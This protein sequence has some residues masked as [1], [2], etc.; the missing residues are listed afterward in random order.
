M[1]EAAVGE[2]AISS[3]EEGM[4]LFQIQQEI[5]PGIWGDV[6]GAST[7]LRIMGNSTYNAAIDMSTRTVQE[8]EVERFR[9]VAR[10]GH[11]DVDMMTLESLQI[12]PYQARDGAALAEQIEESQV[13]FLLYLAALFGLIFGTIMLV[14]YRQ[15]MNSEGEDDSDGVQGEEQTALV[16]AESSG[17]SRSAPPPPPGIST[18]PPPPPPGLSQP[19]SPPPP[20]VANPAPVAAAPSQPAPLQWTDEQLAAQG[21]SPQQIA[22]WRVQQA[23]AAYSQGSTSTEVTG[24][25][26][27][28]RFSERVVDHVMRQHGITDRNAFLAAAEFFDSDG[29][30]YLTTAELS[31]AAE[32]LGEIR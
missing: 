31:K 32:A 13:T 21:W 22:T 27:A 4:V 15:E 24:G 12:Q 25:N 28:A 10:D 2:A 5:A 9:L 6:D 29:N 23:Q 1:E 16:E 14:L 8:P 3:P 26:T 11:I 17:K 7:E 18:S 30:R 20:A 19:A